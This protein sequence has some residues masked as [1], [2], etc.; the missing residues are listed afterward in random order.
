MSSRITRFAL[1]A[2]AA[3]SLSATPV[4]AQSTQTSS[5]PAAGQAGLVPGT[6]IEFTT[7]T[8][9]PGITL[10]PGK[11][12][13]RLGDS[14]ARQNVVE[15]YSSDGSK[16]IATLLTVDYA[17][18]SRAGVSTITFDGTNPPALR[19]WYVP[20]VT[21]GREF[22]WSEDEARSEERRVGKEG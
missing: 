2:A 22:V 7:A 14:V 1:A 12:V 17:A 11:Y 19:A 18:P 16:R 5:T 3:A 9:L 8:R 15:V 13:F 4:L 20:G 21:V 6:T 10:E